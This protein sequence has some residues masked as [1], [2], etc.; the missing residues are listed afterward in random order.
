MLALRNV[1]A[2]LQ[3]E[4]GAVRVSEGKVKDIVIATVRTN[5]LPLM[6]CRGFQGCIAFA[7]LTVLAAAKQVLK[8]APA[9]GLAEAVP[10]ET[11]GKRHMIIWRQQ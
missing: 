7:S 11:V 8:T 1:D 4:S 10:E 2:H 5:P 9:V 6:G 3:D